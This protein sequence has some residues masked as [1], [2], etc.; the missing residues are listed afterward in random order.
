MDEYEFH[1]TA[2]DQEIAVNDRMR[3]SLLEFGCPVCS[4]EVSEEQFVQPEQS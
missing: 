4:T 1:C 3:E 2:C